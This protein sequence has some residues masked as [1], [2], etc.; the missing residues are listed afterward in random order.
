MQHFPSDEELARAVQSTGDSESARVLLSRHQD[1]VFGM[2]L[3]MLR[4]RQDAE[5]LAQEAM[6]RALTGIGSYDPTRPFAPWLFRIARNLCI[7]KRRRQRPQ[8]ELD[9]GTTAA[10]D[11]GGSRFGRRADAVVQ[12]GQLDRAL[13][14]AMGELRPKYREIV[15][16]Y[17]YEHLSYREIAEKLGLPDGTVMNRLFRARRQ[18]AELLEEKGVTP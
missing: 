9:E 11:D 4:N 17:H 16:L 1:A 8:D 10:P 14:E 5:D 15:E 7:D 2:A 13:H 6:V 18:L 12:Q 3:R